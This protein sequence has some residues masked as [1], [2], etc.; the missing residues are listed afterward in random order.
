[1]GVVHV[2]TGPDHLSALITLSANV[3]KCRAFWYGVNWGL[4][5]STGV[6]VVGAIMIAFDESQEEEIDLPKIVSIVL[7]SIVGIAMILMG[8]YGIFKA[9][10]KKDLLQNETDDNY[11]DGDQLGD[12][13]IMSSEFNNISKIKASSSTT[14]ENSTMTEEFHSCQ[15]PSNLDYPRNKIILTARDRCTQLFCCK[16]ILTAYYRCTEFFKDSKFS[17]KVLSFGIGIVHGVAGP[18]GVLG[19]IPAVQLHNWRLASVY[20]FF[21]CLTSTLVMG[22]FAAL[23]G[24]CSNRISNINNIE[25]QMEL[26]SSSISVLV[27][28]LWI[29]LIMIGKLEDI[30]P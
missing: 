5:H 24:I 6:L 22:F 15:N 14:H 7:E 18:G 13:D 30:F 28:V 3:E 26:F 29:F 2:L 8:V 12:R 1:M 10:K 20:L 4:G 27:G 19:V 9:N 21:F 23:Y 16:I 11:V 25:Y 17:N